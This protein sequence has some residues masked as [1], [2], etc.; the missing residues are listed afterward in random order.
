MPQ[1]PQQPGQDGPAPQ[2]PPQAQQPPVQNPPPKKDGRPEG[3]A[4]RPLENSAITG[5]NEREEGKV[6]LTMRNG[7]GK[8]M[9]GVR[10]RSPSATTA[11][12]SGPTV[13]TPATWRRA[14]SSV[15]SWAGG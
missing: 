7:T 12:T 5:A 14:P 1:R 3:P 13:S 8:P 9:K 10:G 11:A 4:R 6:F 2:Q 15:R